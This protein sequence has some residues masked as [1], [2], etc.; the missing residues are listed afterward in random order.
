MRV[1]GTTTHQSSIYVFHTKV[2]T[3]INS[4][5]VF[6]SNPSFHRVKKIQ[7]K[8]LNDFD[9]ISRKKGSGTRAHMETF[10]Q[11]HDIQPNIIMEMLS[12]KSIK[13]AV[14]AA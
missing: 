4:P 12:N 8:V 2:Y 9:F 11:D 3:I 7:P 13:Q 1:N 6:I 10:I 14:I 5:H